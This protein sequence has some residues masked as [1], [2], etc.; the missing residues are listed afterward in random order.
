MNKILVTYATN[1]GST[2]LT[3]WATKP[4]LRPPSPRFC[5]NQDTGCSRI[6]SRRP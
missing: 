3:S 1:S 5:Q 2:A 4:R 6:T